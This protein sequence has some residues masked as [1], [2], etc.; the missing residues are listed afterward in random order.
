VEGLQSR[1]RRDIANA[2]WLK[3][4]VDKAPDWERLAPVPL[5]TLCIRHVP[6]GMRDEALLRAHNLAIADAV[7]QAGRAYLTPSALKGKQMIR[8]SIG[9]EGTERKDVESLWAQLQDVAGKA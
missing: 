8:V 6:N 5:Q 1:L 2:G 4:Q 7:N 9:A 3:D